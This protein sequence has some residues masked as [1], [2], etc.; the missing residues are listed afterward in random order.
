MVTEHFH[1]HTAGDSLGVTRPYYEDTLL[2]RGPEPAAM[3]PVDER[4]EA[5]DE[6]RV[7]P[8]HPAMDNLLRN[9]ET[10]AERNA[11]YGDNWVMCSE[12]MQALFP[13]GVYL[14]TQAQHEMFG[15]LTQM[16]AKLT[17]FA[18]AGALHIDSVRDLSVY[19][20]I[21]EHLITKNG[22][23]GKL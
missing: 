21:A 20:A 23:A 22:D 9:A 4:P 13:D 19:A 6:P 5:D 12:V 11:V 7:N 18:N 2:T 8:P 17:R 1:S 3:P 16:V 10:F 14:K 15:V